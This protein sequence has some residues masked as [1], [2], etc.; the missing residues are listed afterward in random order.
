MI[1][2]LSECYSMCDLIMVSSIQMMAVVERL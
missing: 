1:L 2:F